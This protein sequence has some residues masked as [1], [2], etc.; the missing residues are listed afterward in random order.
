VIEAI[1]SGL[2]KGKGMATK[3]FWTLLLLDDAEV[4]ANALRMLGI[5]ECNDLL[6]FDAGRQE[7]QAMFEEGQANEGAPQKV[8]KTRILLARQGEEA[9]SRPARSL[10]PLSPSPK[11]QRIW[12]IQQ[13]WG[14]TES[15]LGHHCQDSSGERSQR[16]D[17]RENA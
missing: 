10:H 6:D 9:R 12:K 2:G 4:S 15:K 13:L 8:G 3:L 11:G 5:E 17:Y 7:S 14:S 1:D 16:N